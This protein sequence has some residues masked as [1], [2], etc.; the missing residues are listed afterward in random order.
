[1]KR[2]PFLAASPPTSSSWA[3]PCLPGAELPD[4]TRQVIVGY[5]GGAVDLIARAVAQQ[6]QASLGQPI[7]VENR[8]G[9]GNK[10]R[11]A[12]ID[13]PPDGYTL[14]LTANAIAANVT[15]CSHRRTI[16]PAT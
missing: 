5:T 4:E 11:C 8:P 1:M 7:I 2:R 15:L 3:P 9:A 16:S 14:M 6:L 12:L 10:L 13:S